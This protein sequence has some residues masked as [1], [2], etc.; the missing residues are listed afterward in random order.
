MTA[1]NFGIVNHS[2]DCGNSTIDNHMYF[3]V[4]HEGVGNKGGTNVSSLIVKTLHDMKLLSD[5]EVDGE[6]N[7][8]FDN[9][10]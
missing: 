4:Y 6:L 8:I 3:H 5:S 1:N 10:S 9:C 7:I 2:H